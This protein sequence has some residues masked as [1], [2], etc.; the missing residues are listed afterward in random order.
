MSTPKINQT[1]RPAGAVGTASAIKIAQ[2]S[3][4][5][6]AGVSL[7]RCGELLGMTPQGIKAITETADYIEYEEALLNNHL[8]AMD[9]ALAGK[10]DIIHQQFRVAV[11]AAMRCLVES[12]T[13]RRDLKT[14][15]AAAKEI[16]DRDPER[17][18]PTH[19]A[20]EAQ[21]TPKQQLPDEVL[22]Q[23][24]TESNEIAKALNQNDKKGVN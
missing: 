22:A 13:Q 23:A 8:S 15:L 1:G 14:A 18:L 20:K 2:I 4:W 7:V 6:M 16:L 10:E 12:V 24:V 3:R 19:S 17:T 9:E 11:P 5:R 21:E